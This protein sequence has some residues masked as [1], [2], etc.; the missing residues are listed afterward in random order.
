MEMDSISTNK[1]IT[2][3]IVL[4]L[5]IIITLLVMF[6]FQNDIHIAFSQE[7]GYYDDVLELKIEGGAGNRI[8]YTLDGRQP[9]IGDNLYTGNEPI[10]LTDATHNENI[11]S[12]RTDTSTGFFDI[13]YTIPNYHVDKCNVVKAAVFDREGNCLDTITGTYFIGFQDKLSYDG[14]Y[15]ASIVTD[16]H[17]LFD[18]ETGIYTTGAAF[19]TIKE[20][21]HG[22]DWE[23]SWDAN[24]MNRGVEWEREALVTI[25]DESKQIVL[26]ENCGIRIQ[27]GASRAFLPKSIGCF[28]RE[29]Y[30]GSSEFRTDLFQAGIYPH[31]FVFFSGGNDNIFKL[32][33]YLV[34]TLGRELAFSTME[35]IPCAVFLDGEYW[36]VYYIT[37]NYNSDYISDHYR[38]RKDNIV[39]IKNGELIE[40]SEDTEDINF[41]WRMEEFI[42]A[43]DMSLAENYEKACELIDMDSYIDYYAA[44]IYIARCGDWPGSNH[45]S[46]R[47]RND[48]GSVYGDCRWRW[49]LFDVNSSS[50]SIGQVGTDTLFNVLASEPVFRSLYQNN[51]FRIKF[52][53][54]IL[55]MGKEIFAEEKCQAFLDDYVQQMREPIAISSFRFYNEAKMDEFDENV[56]YIRFFFQERYDAVWNSLVNNMGEEW[57]AQNGIQK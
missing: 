24:Y 34:N 16:P 51:E 31:K 42:S 54:R 19:D 4:L 43:N 22:T 48:D 36:G 21:L 23:W 30:N 28:A 56:E 2:L 5:I 14:I 37:E 53:E 57:L 40:G 27:G 17:N 26:S 18:Y 15:S 44:S 46:W 32:K 50:M 33:D 11:Y 12:A 8:Y 52:A 47:T 1:K 10:I 6:S 20:S 29:I 3:G 13:G 25:F 7:S 55:Y 41:F 38:V 45:A 49:M 39:M 35:F 9:E